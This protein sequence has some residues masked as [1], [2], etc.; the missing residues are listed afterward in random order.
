MLS[1]P[2]LWGGGGS[3][4]RAMGNR[5]LTCHLEQHARLSPVVPLLESAPVL[6]VITWVDLAN[7]QRHTSLV[8]TV[9]CP[10]HPASVAFHLQPCHLGS[11]PVH[12]QR[13][14]GVG[15]VPPHLHVCCCPPGEEL[16]CQQG[17]FPNFGQDGKGRTS[18]PEFIY[19]AV[20]GKQRED[21]DARFEQPRGW[22]LVPG[23]RQDF[24]SM[25]QRTQAW[26]SAH[27]SG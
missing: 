25:F 2:Q 9:L 8:S 24:V 12:N 7:P 3:Q 26:E 16:T 1:R 23:G 14:I 10:L 5:T 18:D 27:F 11:M 13:R 21:G 4:E 6:P 19:R 15:P 20:K 17:I 22:D